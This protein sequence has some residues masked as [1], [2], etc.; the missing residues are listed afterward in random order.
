ML[1][2]PAQPA[3]PDLL[4]KL[5]QHPHPRPMPTQ[6]AEAPPSSLFGQLRHHQVER[7]GRGQQ[8]QQMRTPQLRR[9]QSAT[10]PTR[11]SP[12]AKIVDESVRN[13][14]GQQIQQAMGAGWRK[15]ITHA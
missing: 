13:I 10:T 11:K 6:P 2:D 9:T 12:W 15:N 5:L 8:C 7:V 14:R 3:H 4:T 1:I